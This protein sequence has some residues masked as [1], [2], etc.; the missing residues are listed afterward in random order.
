VGGDELRV[1]NVGANDMLTIRKYATKNSPAIDI[2][3]P[4]AEAVIYRG[5]LKRSGFLLS[6][7]VPRAG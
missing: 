1:V 4:N 2:I 7:T 5:P 3:P 6:T